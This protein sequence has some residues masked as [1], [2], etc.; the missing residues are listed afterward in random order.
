[1]NVN[2]LL[3]EL[4]S[5]RAG[6]YDRWTEKCLLLALCILHSAV[7]HADNKMSIPPKNTEFKY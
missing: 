6:N 3:S 7:L 1:M 4:Y 5:S 2:T